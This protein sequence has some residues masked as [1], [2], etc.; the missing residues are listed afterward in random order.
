MKK[1]SLSFALALV[2]GCSSVPAVPPAS[3]ADL[4][5]IARAYVQ[6][7]FS[8]DQRAI[9]DLTAPAFVEIS[10][11]GEVD[12]RDEVL[13]FYAPE[14]RASAPGFTIGN[15]QVRRTGD[16]AVVTQTITIGQAPRTVSLS[17]GLTAAHV[18][19]TWKITSSQTTPMPSGSPGK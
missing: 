3:S 5:A 13:A 15:V 16:T 7:Q 14:K 19:G 10:P 1:L 17:Q 12:E 18:G 11:K 8:F 4:E 2:A 6:A 9:R